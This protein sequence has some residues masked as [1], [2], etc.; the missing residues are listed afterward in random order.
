MKRFSR[1]QGLLLCLLTVAAAVLFLIGVACKSYWALAVPV[2]MGFLWLMGMGFWIG[3]TLL[4][5][6]VKPEEE[7]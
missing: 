7:Q 3:W 4:T 2:A 6:K 5:I 1:I